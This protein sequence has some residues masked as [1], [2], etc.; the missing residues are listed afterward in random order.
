MQL[1]ILYVSGDETCTCEHVI[2]V[3]YESA[4][5]AAVDFETCCI[6]MEIKN[7]EIHKANQTSSY[8]PYEYEFEFAGKKWYYND[9]FEG[10]TYY[11]P[12]ILTINEWFDEE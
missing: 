6:E 8:T 2:P 9:F 1:V 4:E 7:A 3:E 11:P 10:N 5:A 12:T